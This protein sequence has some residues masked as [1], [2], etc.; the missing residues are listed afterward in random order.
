[1]R[2]AP[3]SKNLSCNRGGYLVNLIQARMAEI[4]EWLGHSGI[5]ILWVLI[6]LI[7]IAG[8]VLSCLSLSGTWLVVVATLITMLLRPADF[9]GWWTITSFVLLSTAVELAEWLAAAWGV[10]RRGGSGW[11]G[12]AAVAGGLAG[13]LAGALIPIPVV[14]SLIGMMGGSFVCAFAVER[15][16]LQ[17]AGHAAYIA[18]G[19]VLGRIV[20]IIIKVVATLG[21]ISFLIMGLI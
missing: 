6:W 20:V 11:A 7:C 12:W 8:V 9:P 18:R 13:L 21:M 4:F 5:L 14:G 15:Y 3:L 10:T 17:H 16:R 2:F 1:M 19:A